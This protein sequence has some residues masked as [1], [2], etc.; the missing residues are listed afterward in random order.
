M[1]V[2]STPSWLLHV[3]LFGLLVGGC[4]SSEENSEF[5][6]ENPSD[7]NSYACD[8]GALGGQAKALPPQGEARAC[9]DN[10][11]CTTLYV[12]AHRGNMQRGAPANSIQAIRDTAAAHIPFAEIDI[13]TTQDGVMVLH[14]DANP[15]GI[16]PISS[17]TWDALQQHTITGEDGT[18]HPV[19]TFEAVMA[20]AQDLGIGLYLDIKDVD[21]DALVDTIQRYDAQDWALIRASNTDRLQRMVELDDSLWFFTDADTLQDAKD[22]RVIFENIMLAGLSHDAPSSLIHALR[23]HGFHV[24]L[25]VLGGPDFLWLLKN[26]ARGYLKA[27]DDGANMLQTDYPED[28]LR[29]LCLR[30]AGYFDTPSP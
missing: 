24:Q 26:D 13:R 25:D 20:E 4:N 21:Y 6:V 2:I 18:T 19:P 3:L 8:H 30:D 1:S 27:I 9:L 12:V 28:L 14:H 11:L 23:D 22:A 17:M 29:I 10:P 5:I 16:G 15:S 7:P